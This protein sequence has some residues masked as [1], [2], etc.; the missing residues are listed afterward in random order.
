MYFTFCINFG[1]GNEKEMERVE[2][3]VV[4]FHDALPFLF[5]FHETQVLVFTALLELCM[6]FTNGQNPALAFKGKQN[7]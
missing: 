6:Q 1:T 7:D 3:T 5:K 2:E 4:Q